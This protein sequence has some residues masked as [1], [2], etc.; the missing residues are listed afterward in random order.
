MFGLLVCCWVS[1]T[2]CGDDD[3]NPS[4]GTAASAASGDAQ[5]DAQEKV[6]GSGCAPIVDLLT[7]KQLCAQL[8]K[9]VGQCGTQFNAYYDCSAAD[10]FMCAG[11]L[12]TN[13]T[14]ACDD[15]LASLNRCRNGGT[16][17]SGA[18][19]KGANPSG[20]CPQVACPCPGGTKMVS[21]FDNSS[22]SCECLDT[23]TC[24]ELFCD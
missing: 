22:G 21:G 9:S 19:C 15:E 16:G 24:K 8:V 13:K 20:T 11:P 17:G 12:V 3:A 23:N 4:G 5:C 7:C 2:S 6:R 14:S 1:A 18:S 10:G